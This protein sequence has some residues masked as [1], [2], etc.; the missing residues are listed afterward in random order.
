[1]KTIGLLGGMSWESTKTYYHLLNTLVKDRLGGLNSAKILLNSVNFGELESCLRDSDWR[2]IEEILVRE[3]QRVERGG[4]DCLLLCTNTMHKIFDSLQKNISIP[5]FHIADTLGERLSSENVRCVGILGTRFTMTEN[6]YSDRLRERFDISTIVPSESDTKI[7]DDIIF[8]EL[9]IGVVSDESRRRYIE[10]MERLG[11]SGADSIA[12]ACT[13]LELLLSPSD[14]PLPLFDA[15][16]IHC[17][18]AVDW[19]LRD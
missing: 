12:L 17:D 16:R 9:C 18:Y 5:F 15:T 14:S 11:E 6:F 1:M 4:A 19:C 13:E 2:T 10:I 7:A 3:S 8:E